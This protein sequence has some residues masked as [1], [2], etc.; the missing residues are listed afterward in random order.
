MQA[1][2]HVYASVLLMKSVP[3][4]KSGVLV[5][6]DIDSGQPGWLTIAVSEGVGGAVSGQTAEELRINI[7]SGSVRLM[8]HATE[9]YKRVLL[10]EGGVAKVR[11]SGLEAVL[12]ETEIKLLM[13]FA[14]NVPERFPSLRESHGQPVP[15]DIE[16]G[17]Y[18]N[19]LMLFQIRPFLES[20]KARKNLLLN[21]LDDRL[22][23]NHHKVVNLNQI[24]AE[25]RQ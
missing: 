17:F 16:F 4:E 21:S 20:V 3:A 7:Q 12:N 19:R 1:P 2:E 24:P 6:A 22:I 5:T 15:A 25:E 18:Q 10:R 8:A 13:E 11:A 9:P 14:V 23:Q